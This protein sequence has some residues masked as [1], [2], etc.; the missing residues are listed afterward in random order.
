MMVVC[1]YLFVSTNMK[2]VTQIWLPA[3]IRQD[4]GVSRVGPLH[5]V[6]LLNR[7]WL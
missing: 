2:I 4:L 3:L 7:K 6:R 5:L 1:L